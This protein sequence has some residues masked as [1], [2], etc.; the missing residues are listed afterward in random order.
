MVSQLCTGKMVGVIK[1]SWDE[2]E[3]EIGVVLQNIRMEILMEKKKI[4]GALRL[5][6]VCF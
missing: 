3:K 4:K 1:M 5:K 2:V 6:L